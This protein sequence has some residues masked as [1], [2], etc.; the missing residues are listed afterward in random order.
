MNEWAPR[1]LNFP[2][3]VRRRNGREVSREIHLPDAAVYEA[4]FALSDRTGDRLP[5]IAEVA[6][7]L[8]EVPDFGSE[9]PPSLCGSAAAPCGVSYAAGGTDEWSRFAYIAVKAFA[10]IRRTAGEPELRW[11]GSPVHPPGT[12][13]G[14]GLQV[15]TLSRDRYRAW[16]ERSAAGIIGEPL[17]EIECLGGRDWGALPSDG[18]PKN[19]H[20]VLRGAVERNP[21]DNT[22]ASTDGRNAGC[23]NADLK[24]WGLRV[25]RGGAYRIRGFLKVRRGAAE[26]QV[27]IWHYFDR[28]LRAPQAE[29]ARCVGRVYLK[30]G[31]DRKSTRLDSS[32]LGI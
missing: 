28:Y 30:R 14:W 26:A 1:A 29:A 12:P 27:R 13:D 15:E 19:F 20:L 21:H 4:S 17:M 6:T 25:E 24:H 8:I 9:V 16:K 5:E 31:A 11:A 3:D 32:H 22:D 10:E 2:G 7:E 23:P 18:R